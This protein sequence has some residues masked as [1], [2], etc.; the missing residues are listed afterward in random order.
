[1]KK[2]FNGLTSEKVSFVI[3]GLTIN[4]LVPT[5][6]ELPSSC[7][8]SFFMKVI[9]YRVVN[10]PASSGPNP[11][12]TQKLIWSPNHVRKIPKVKLGLKNLGM[13]PSYFDYIFMHLRQKVRL[14]LELSLKFLSLL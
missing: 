8:H 6:A 4:G 13:P 7:H 9:R 2:L 12:R 3:N 14:G 11:S 1:M 10:G 5:Y